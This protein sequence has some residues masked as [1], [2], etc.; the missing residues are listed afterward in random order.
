MFAITGDRYNMVG[1]CSESLGTQTFNRVFVITE[2]VITEI[3]ITEFVLTEII[4]AE[5]V[6]T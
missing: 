6:I 4:I 3:V 1:L 5:L 2:F